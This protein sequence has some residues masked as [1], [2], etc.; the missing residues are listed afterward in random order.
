M[1]VPKPGAPDALVKLADGSH[2]HLSEFWQDGRLL[3]VFLRH[4]G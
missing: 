2:R 1:K 3:L 4:L